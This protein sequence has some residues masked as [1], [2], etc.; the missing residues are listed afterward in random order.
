LKSSAIEAL[1]L[2]EQ[3][4]TAPVRVSQVDA[5]LR[6]AAG[7]N[8][9]TRAVDRRIKLVQHESER[10]LSVESHDGNQ[11]VHRRVVKK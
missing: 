3:S 10:L 2:R 5:F 6:E 4:K 7:G 1:R 11:W 9:T 8:E